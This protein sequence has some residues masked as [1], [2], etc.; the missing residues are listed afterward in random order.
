MNLKNWLDKGTITKEQYKKV[1]D[2]SYLVCLG[3]ETNDADKKVYHQSLYY[4]SFP[5]GL[6]FYNQ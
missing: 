1:L 2:K 4:F 5:R 6:K 3:K